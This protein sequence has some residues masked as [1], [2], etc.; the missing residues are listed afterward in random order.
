MVWLKVRQE[1]DGGVT[2]QLGVGTDDKITTKWYYPNGWSDITFF[3]VNSLG[4]I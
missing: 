3:L 4:L 1:V 2:A